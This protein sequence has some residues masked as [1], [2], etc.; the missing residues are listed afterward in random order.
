MRSVTVHYDG[1]GR[2][3]AIIEAP[4]DPQAPPAGIQPLPGC[5]EWKTELS[6]ELEWMTLLDLHVSHQVDVSGET[7]RLVKHHGT[8]TRT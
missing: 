6:G 4:R 8:K 5:K 3:K 7:P 2:I 1:S